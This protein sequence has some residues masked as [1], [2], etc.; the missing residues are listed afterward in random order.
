[1]EEAAEA[2]D[3]GQSTNDEGS[4][5]HEIRNPKQVPTPE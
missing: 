4:S 1:M 2:N 3:E 5:K